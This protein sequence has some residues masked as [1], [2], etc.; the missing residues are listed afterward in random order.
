MQQ[1]M[2]YKKP[3]PQAAHLHLHMKETPG[4]LCHGYLGHPVTA[5]PLTGSSCLAGAQQIFLGMAGRLA[6]RRT[7]CAGS[8]SVAQCC[9]PS[10][11][12][13]GQLQRPRTCPVYTSLPLP[14]GVGG[15]VA[16][17]THELSFHEDR[18]PVSQL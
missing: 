17:P 10:V 13:G 4:H 11:G 6:K 2:D 7:G 8:G 18:A 3:G 12:L 9:V 14:V 15:W 5:F 1:G 16:S